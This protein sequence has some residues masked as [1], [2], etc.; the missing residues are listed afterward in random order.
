[1]HDGVIRVYD[2]SSNVIETHERAGEFT[3]ADAVSDRYQDFA[4]SNGI[5]VE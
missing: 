1:M 5:C 4:P 2:A 3:P